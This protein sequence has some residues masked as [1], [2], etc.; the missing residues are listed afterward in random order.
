M[1]ARNVHITRTLILIIAVAASLAGCVTTTTLDKR[2]APSPKEP[3]TPPPAA[4]SP[5]PATAAAASAPALPFA[6]QFPAELDASRQSLTLIQ[7]VDIGLGN[8]ALTRLAWSQA[9]SAAAALSA[10]QSSN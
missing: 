4:T 3:W 9:R 2:I 10:A 7:L 8:N 6:P 5:P 1:S